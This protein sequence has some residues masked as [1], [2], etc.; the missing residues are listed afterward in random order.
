MEETQGAAALPAAGQ[1]KE[2]TGPKVSWIYN[3]RK[4]DI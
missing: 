1:Q 4:Q 3:L 2:D